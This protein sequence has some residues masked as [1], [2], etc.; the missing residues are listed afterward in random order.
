MCEISS[1]TA[2]QCCTLKENTFNIATL[3]VT[4]YRLFLHC[5][6]WRASLQNSE[7]LSMNL[8]I[9]RSRFSSR[10]RISS[11]LTLLFDL[12]R[13]ITAGSLEMGERCVASTYTYKKYTRC[14]VH[15]IAKGLALLFKRYGANQQVIPLILFDFKSINLF[16]ISVP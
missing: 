11:K 2:L 7:L 10:C 1:S 3:L 16:T 12:L 15:F 8:C 4:P 9:G 5:A 14:Q 6:L 13:T